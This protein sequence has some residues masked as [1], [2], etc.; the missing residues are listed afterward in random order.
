VVKNALRVPHLRCGSVTKITFT[1]RTGSASGKEIKLRT[2]PEPQFFA[3]PVTKQNITDIK[4]H[5]IIPGS[6]SCAGSGLSSAI[7][8]HLFIQQIWQFCPNLKVDG[9]TDKDRLYKQNMAGQLSVTLV[10]TIERK[11]WRSLIYRD[12]S[13]KSFFSYLYAKRFFLGANSKT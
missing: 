5:K 2:V 6:A 10:N 7:F 11:I 13:Q 8:T 12:T 4:M 1:N 9:F 3:A